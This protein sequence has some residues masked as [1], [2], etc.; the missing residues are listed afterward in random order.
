MIYTRA[1]APALLALL[2]VT[3]S[4]SAQWGGGFQNS[5]LGQYGYGYGR[6]G[7]GMGGGY[8]MGG[9]GMGGFM[10]GMGPGGYMMGLASVTNANGQYQMQIQQARIEQQQA[11][12]ERCSKL[13]PFS[14]PEIDEKHEVNGEQG[15]RLPVTCDCDCRHD[16]KH[17]RASV[18]QVIQA[19]AV[20]AG[21]HC[22]QHP[23]NK[24]ESPHAPLAREYRR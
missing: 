17:S 16:S 24:L 11:E 8:G 4:A 14:A 22:H 12:R 19:T 9:Y 13:E 7:G 6:G 3:G 20:W 5:W 15:V 23:S 18:D 1:F 21:R 10:P 2:M